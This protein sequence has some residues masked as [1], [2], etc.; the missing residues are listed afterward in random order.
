M[1]NDPLELWKASYRFSV[2]F[3]SSNI[4][5]QQTILN[6]EQ[7]KA[8][9]AWNWDNHSIRLTEQNNR[10]SQL[11]HEPVLGKTQISL[12]WDQRWGDFPRNF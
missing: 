9:Q 3:V 10:K 4:Y 1:E 2:R 7:K 11:Q 8:Q 6:G 5:V 12:L